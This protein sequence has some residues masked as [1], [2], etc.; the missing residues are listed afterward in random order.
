MMHFKQLR[1]LIFMG[2]L[3]TLF[4]FFSFSQENKGAPESILAESLPVSREVSEIQK[5]QEDLQTYQNRLNSLQEDVNRLLERLVEGEEDLKKEATRAQA[6]IQVKEIT[7]EEFE[8]FFDRWNMIFDS[9][10]DVLKDVKNQIEEVT[11]IKNHFDSKMLI[12]K[13]KLEGLETDKN[14]SEVIEQRNHIK[15]LLKSY[16]KE[17]D[18]I[19]KLLL[20]LSKSSA[21]LEN[22]LNQ[23][24][25]TTT[26][27]MN[28]WQTIQLSRLKM[29][30]SP[31]ISYDNLEIASH[32]FVYRVKK[33]PHF[34]YSLGQY[35]FKTLQQ[36]FQNI[37]RIILLSF[38]LSFLIGATQYLHFYSKKLLQKEEEP[39]FIE[40]FLRRFFVV[41]L[42]SQVWFLSL[43]LFGIYLFFF[44]DSRSS[45][46]VFLFLSIA[47][48]YSTW[49]FYRA[50]KIIL[51]GSLK[52]PRLFTATEK[53]SQ[54]LFFRSTLLL[55]T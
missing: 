42:K 15:S 34:F 51:I 21:S 31:K 40:K 8:P 14:N 50:L 10:E 37:S 26:H 25:D 35:F 9:Y 28:R 20:D 1:F 47:L 6:I 32:E 4:P 2:I 55:F 30:Q 36:L 45:E 12:W 46:G 43:S 23:Y 39:T 7:L 49:L 22:T 33:I 48:L 29:K 3:I 19:S 17:Q 18:H 11:E 13:L 53:N 5:A 41:F 24:R 54:S 44:N 52:H 16:D 38:I 27:L